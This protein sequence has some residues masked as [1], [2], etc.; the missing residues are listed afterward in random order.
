MKKQT[1]ISLFSGILVIC[2]FF[3]AVISRSFDP[4]GL[5]KLAKSFSI[6]NR[7]DLPLKSDT[8][9]F[10]EEGEE[11]SEKDLGSREFKHTY[12]II[13]APHFVAIVGGPNFIDPQ[14]RGYLAVQGK[15]L[16][17]VQR[18]LKL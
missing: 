12:D 6:E 14:P 8:N 1:I 11:K 7:T 3:T 18:S 10:D 9:L 16:Y 15:I 13:E 17:L 4:F 5:L 2:F